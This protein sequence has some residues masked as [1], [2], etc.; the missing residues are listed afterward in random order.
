M[1]AG[2][3]RLLV[4][5]DSGD[6]EWR[7]E[8]RRWDVTVFAVA[9]QPAGYTAAMRRVWD[10]GPQYSNGRVFF[11]EEDFV[12]T[13]PVDLDDLHA[14]L[15]AHPQLAQVALQR[16]PWFRSEHRTGVLPAQ[17][18]RVD[19]ERA[20]LGRPGTT[21]TLHA[22]CI[23]HDA[24]FTGNPSLIAAAAFDVP[25]PA[26]EWSETAMGQAL[27]AAGL[28]SAWYGREGDP[29]HVEHRG[30]DRAEHSGGY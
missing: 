10:L 14:V 7:A 29:P 3:D 13:R 27:T 6:P 9:D 18:M 4:V 20:A 24:G 15:D 8:L 28:T 25:W 19:R 12:F 5:D 23:E 26:A 17:R 21:W 11:L 1:V 16:A 22:D 2:W 30:R